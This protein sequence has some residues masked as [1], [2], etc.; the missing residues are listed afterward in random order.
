MR[1]W[2]WY[3]DISEAVFQQRGIS[4]WLNAALYSTCQCCLPAA[5]L[6][7]YT[8]LHRDCLFASVSF[9]KL[10][11][12]SFF[13]T[14][15]HSLRSDFSLEQITLKKKKNLVSCCSFLSKCLDFNLSNFI[16]FPCMVSVHHVF[17]LKW[18]NDKKQQR[19]ICFISLSVSV[20]GT[21]IFILHAIYYTV[22]CSL[23]V[24]THMC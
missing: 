16:F 24:W 22:A 7:D 12:L 3:I 18:S 6:Y 9:V 20:C 17:D 13:F 8:I 10:I 21:V 4:I 11:L 23:F 5:L 2:C 15:D 1:N 14:K 19:C